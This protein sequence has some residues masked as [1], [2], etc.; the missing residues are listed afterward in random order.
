MILIEYTFIGSF[1][2]SSA[3]P[4]QLT[5]VPRPLLGKILG[6]NPNESPMF[7]YSPTIYLLIGGWG[8]ERESI[9]RYQPREELLWKMLGEE[10]KLVFYHKRESVSQY[11]HMRH[12]ET[13]P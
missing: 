9:E 10:G 11:R 5:G 7:P 6:K 3:F 8:I 4:A 1:S 13:T 2:G 12:Q